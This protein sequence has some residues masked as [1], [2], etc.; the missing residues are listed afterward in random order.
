MIYAIYAAAI[1]GTFI[2]LFGM[3]G[4]GEWSSNIAILGGWIWIGTIVWGFISL[5]HG[6][7]LVIGTLVFGAILQRILR[8]IMNPHGR[9]ARM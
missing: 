4:R 3:E 6:L 9:L 2:M 5:R 1:L 7:L 8:P